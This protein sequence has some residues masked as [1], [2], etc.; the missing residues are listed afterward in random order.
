MGATAVREEGYIPSV[1]Q[2]GFPVTSSVPVTWVVFLFQLQ[3]SN[4]GFE[5]DGGEAVPLTLLK[6]CLSSSLSLQVPTA[7]VVAQYS[8]YLPYSALAVHIK[9]ARESVGVE[10]H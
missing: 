6:A 10:N 2:Q 1:F 3:L 9:E 5:E 8:V 7:G 4:S